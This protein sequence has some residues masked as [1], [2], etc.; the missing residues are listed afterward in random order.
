MICGGSGHWARWRETGDYRKRCCAVISIHSFH[1]VRHHLA[2]A[3]LFNLRWNRATTM[4][5]ASKGAELRIVSITPEQKKNWRLK[6]EHGLRVYGWRYRITF[7]AKFY[8]DKYK[9][10]RTDRQ[11]NQQY[12][13]VLSTRNGNETTDIME[14]WDVN[15]ESS[16]EE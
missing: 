4:G 12:Y 15:G 13:W 9:L 10:C 2:L 3:F 8:L 7:I 16:R 6:G 1:I 14:G 5:I 11:W